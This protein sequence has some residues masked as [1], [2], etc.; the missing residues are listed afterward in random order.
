MKI[1]RQ[2][3]DKIRVL[4]IT[5]QNNHNWIISS[6]LLKKY[7]VETGIFKV[8]LYFK[9]WLQS[10]KRKYKPPYKE[11]DVILLNYNGYSWSRTSEEGLVEFVKSGRGLV[12]YHSANNSFPT[13]TEYNQMIGLGGWGGRDETAGPKIYWTENTVIRD[14]SP[15]K[16]GKHGKPHVFEIINR[17][18]THPITKDLP[19]KWLHASD[20]LYSD[21]RG[22][23]ENITI[24]STAF[25]NARYNGNNRDEPVLF[26]INYGDGRIFHTTLG[27]IKTLSTYPAIRCTGF[28]TTF[29]RGV[30]WAATGN[31]SQA[32]PIYFPDMSVIR[33]RGNLLAQNKLIEKSYNLSN[34]INSSAFKKG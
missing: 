21:L 4:I 13:W 28:I 12:V 3:R 6:L 10:N 29:Q 16:A 33:M 2:E 24:L 9:Y 11:Y 19:E 30:E 32:A 27:H 14:Y 7:L 18:K 26:T 17:E 5:G 34:L 25:S 20:E 15:G 23:A 31:V 22:P 1:S 8:A